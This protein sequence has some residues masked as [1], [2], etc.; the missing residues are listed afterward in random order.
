MSD[1][2]IRLLTDGPSPDAVKSAAYRQFTS[3][4]RFAYSA[5]ESVATGG[6]AAK[7]GAYASYALRNVG[8]AAALLKCP[9]YS[10]VEKLQ[11]VSDWLESKGASGICAPVR[12]EEGHICVT[13]RTASQLMD[14]MRTYLDS[15]FT[16]QR[17]R[18]KCEE[19]AKPR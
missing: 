15:Y 19:A 4:I 5:W 10:A 13:K 14:D 7:M 9:E 6:T 16:L 2:D 1:V 17:E 12:T 3:A 18:Q 8:E 11:R